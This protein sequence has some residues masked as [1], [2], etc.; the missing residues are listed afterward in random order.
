MREENWNGTGPDRTLKSEHPPSRSMGNMAHEAAG[1]FDLPCPHSVGRSN[2]AL[3]GVLSEAESTS[4]HSN[5]PG[6][7]SS[8]C[9]LMNP[10]GDQVALEAVVSE[11]CCAESASSRESMSDRN[12]LGASCLGTT[13]CVFR[14][15][16]RRREG[17]KG[18]SMELEWEVTGTGKSSSGT[19]KSSTSCF[20]IWRFYY[21]VTRL[22]S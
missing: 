7:A 4:A 14:A 5:V 18:E 20:I 11:P 19:G 17:S 13:C 8:T 15:V 3:N 6:N 12:A 9:N 21:G 16:D 2:E 1:N 22:N 10:P